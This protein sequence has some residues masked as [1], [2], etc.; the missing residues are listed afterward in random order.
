MAHLWDMVGLILCF[1]RV[2]P[3][4]STAMLLTA[5]IVGIADHDSRMRWSSPAG[6]GTFDVNFTVPAMDDLHSRRRLVRIITAQ[7]FRRPA[8]HDD[9]LYLKNKSLKE[10]HW[11]LKWR[12]TGAD[13]SKPIVLRNHYNVVPIVSKAYSTIDL[14]SL[15]SSRIS[16][17]RFPNEQ[18]TT[19]FKLRIR[20]LIQ[21][22]PSRIRT[23][24]IVTPSFPRTRPIH[25]HPQ[26]SI[27]LPNLHDATHSSGSGDSFPTSLETID[28]HS[29]ASPINPPLASKPPTT[30]PSSHPC[31]SKAKATP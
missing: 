19:H 3:T 16:T 27:I 1:F 21:G 4:S 8:A 24:A 14:L 17:S 13:V 7:R 6:W 23:S 5:H 22:T 11:T 29:N 30:Q 25:S 20:I 9:K 10:S 31:F 26:P 15:L 18:C 12:E 28:M 2:W